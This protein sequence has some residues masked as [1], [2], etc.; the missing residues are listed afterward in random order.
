M[1]KRLTVAYSACFWWLARL[2]KEARLADSPSKYEILPSNYVTHFNIFKIYASIS[3][4][5]GKINHQKKNLALTLG[6]LVI[7]VRKLFENA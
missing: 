7:F 4:Q 6:K 2:A 5:Y 1:R 3:V